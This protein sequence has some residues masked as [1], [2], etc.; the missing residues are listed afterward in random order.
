MK[1]ILLALFVC[2]FFLN[3]YGTNFNIVNVGLTF[4][5][6][7]VN[8]TQN[9]VITFT[10]ASF[11]DAVEYSESSLHAGRDKGWNTHR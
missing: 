8:I 4:S 11:H 2:L 1:K 5:P 7:A 6:A 10:L 3:S 9:D